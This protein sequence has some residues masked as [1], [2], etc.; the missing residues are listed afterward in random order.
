MAR[1]QMAGVGKSICH[2]HYMDDIH[3]CH[4]KTHLLLGHCDMAYPMLQHGHKHKE[5]LA[6]SRDLLFR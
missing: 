1:P 2:P 6:L 3:L 4:R 5:N